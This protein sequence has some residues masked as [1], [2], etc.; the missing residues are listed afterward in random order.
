MDFKQLQYLLKV[1]ECQNIT[2]ASEQ[3]YVS[4]PALSNYISKVEEE[5][6]TKIF[7]RSSNPLTLTQAGECYMKTAKKILALQK[8]MK[9]EIE[10][11]NN[12]KNGVIKLGLSEMRATSLLPFILPEFQRLYPN[13]D[14]HTIESSGREVEANVLAGKVNMGILPLYQ[15]D[16]IFQRQVLYDEELV[17]VSDKEIPSHKGEI[18]QWVDLEELN[19]Q[20]FA[21]LAS[22]M[23][24]RDAVDSIFMEHGVKP[25]K[26]LESSNHMT[27]YLLATAGTALTIVPE[28]V[29]RLVNPIH[30]PHIYSI[31][32]K[33]FHWD[34]GAIWREEEELNSAEQL[35]IRLIRSRY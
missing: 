26:I 4:Q 33:G 11:L 30:S 22:H 25:G 16:D 32:K 3:L 24:M 29:V 20:K 23:R 13:V 5:L 27:L 35:L 7:N 2:R 18:R 34:I 19:G 1:A 14:L 17:L 28:A 10:D 8:T 21:M 6:G 12:C 15:V 9:E 31:G